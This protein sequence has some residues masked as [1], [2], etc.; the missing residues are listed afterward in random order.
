MTELA[1][2]RRPTRSGWAVPLRAAG[3]AGRRTALV[4]TAA[5][6][7]AACSGGPTDIAGVTIE[8]PGGWDRVETPANPEVVATATWRGGRAQA[9]S[10]QVVVGCGPGSV[11]DLANAAVTRERPPLTVTDAEVDTDVEVAGADAAIGLDLTLGAGRDDDAATVVVQGV[12]AQVGEALVLV[13]FSTPVRDADDALVDT[14]L[15]SVSL[16]R[17]VLA[18]ACNAG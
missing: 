18:E 4:A 17:S 11:A 9:S 3:R 16:D 2:W 12:Y 15:G 7:A 1:P 8:V 6:L 13:E 14:T 10:L 5:L